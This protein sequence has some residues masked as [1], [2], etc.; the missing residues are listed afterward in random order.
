MT[1]WLGL[2]FSDEADWLSV[3]NDSD[4]DLYFT[5]RAF[6]QW[7]E[8]FYGLQYPIGNVDHL[9]SEQYR[10]LCIYHLSEHPE[11]FFRQSFVADPRASAAELLSRRDELLS[12]GLKLHRLPE[13]CP[14]R[15]KAI[16]EIEKI[17]LDAHSPLDLLPGFADRL[18]ELIHSIPQNRHPN[19][20]LRVH[21][22]NDL[23]PPGLLR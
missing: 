7:L 3:K 8:Q 22:P 14:G 15:L 10:Q 23:L 6:V 2:H 4:S 18:N 11:A 5:P 21:E 17:V 16:G 12:A 13:N 19:F 20:D 9:R 1:V